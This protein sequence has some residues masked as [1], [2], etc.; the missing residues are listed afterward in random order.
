M[1]LQWWHVKARMH[2]VIEFNSLLMNGCGSGTLAYNFVGNMD[3]EFPKKGDIYRVLSIATANKS[4]PL[5]HPLA[6]F[7]FVHKDREDLC[8][9]F[10]FYFLWSLMKGNEYCCYHSSCQASYW[11]TASLVP[12]HWGSGQMNIFYRLPIHFFSYY[13]LGFLLHCSQR[14]DKNGVQRYQ[15]WKLALVF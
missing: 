13:D 4:R 10:F 11:T 7:H 5:G 15:V 12:W 1:T 9:T 3:Y 8:Y 2:Y 6:W 14:L